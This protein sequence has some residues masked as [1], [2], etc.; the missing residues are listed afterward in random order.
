MKKLLLLL[1]LIPH[2]ASAEEKMIPVADYIASHS[3]W[4]S[5]LYEMLYVSNRCGTVYLEAHRQIEDDNEEVSKA[6]FNKSHT[7]LLNTAYYIDALFKGNEIDYFPQS[8]EYEMGQ[9]HAFYMRE[10][11]NSYKGNNTFKGM[12]NDDMNTCQSFF[13]FFE[14]LWSEAV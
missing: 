9:I 3:N 4:Q 7:I 11:P 5:N 14:R 2:L 8:L 6:L 12:V 13:G 10:V 1:F